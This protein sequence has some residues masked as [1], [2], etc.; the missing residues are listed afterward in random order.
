V[1]V[2]AYNYNPVGGERMVYQDDVALTVDQIT[3]LAVDPA[4]HL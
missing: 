1:R 2:T 4:L 3:R